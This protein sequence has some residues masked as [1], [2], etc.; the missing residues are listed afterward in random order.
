MINNSQIFLSAKQV[1]NFLIGHLIDGS[2][3][4]A[5]FFQIIVLTDSFSAADFLF[6]FK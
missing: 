3:V 1:I 2:S 6:V 4:L 5:L